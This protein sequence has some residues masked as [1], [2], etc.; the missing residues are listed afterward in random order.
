MKT[1]NNI[2]EASQEYAPP[3]IEILKIEIEKGFEGSDPSDPGDPNEG[4]GV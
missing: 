3:V 1:L 4:D 2:L